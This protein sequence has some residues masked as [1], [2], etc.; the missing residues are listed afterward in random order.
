MVSSVIAGMESERNAAASAAELFGHEVL[1]SETIGASPETPQRACLDLVRRSD[2]VVLILGDR[3][4]SVPPGREM[5]PTHEEYREAR[6]LGKEVL[7]YMRARD[8]EP[9]QRAF[10]DEVR[11]W[12]SGAVMTAFNTPDELR[13]LVIRGLRGIE[14]ARA[15]GG[16]DPK[17]MLARA[18]EAL[19][20][21][22]LR[23]NEPSLALAVAF[24]PAQQALR[25]RQLGEGEFQRQLERDALYGDPAVLVR[26]AGIET[27]IAKGRL[28]LK[29]ERAMLTLATD[30]TIAL[31]VP[32]AVERDDLPMLIEEDV[33]EL[34]RRSLQFAGQLIER[35]DPTGR[36]TD[37]VPV[38]SIGSV[39]FSPWMTR[40]ERARARH[41]YTMNVHAPD[42][43][44]A[45]LQ[46][47]HRRRRALT[48]EA[49]SI[50]EDLT[51]LIRQRI[52]E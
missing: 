44:D 36:L 51:D 52:V 16:T 5:A 45:A 33:V 25:P 47:P 21:V 15:A 12:T 19:D 3:Y 14:L 40:A 10:I 26:G 50:A 7:V 27:A 8:P 22:S 20:G 4:G 37:A 13:D 42:R 41:G 49:L 9:R 18:R 46:P 2:S 24:G 39:G 28:V 1:R 38:A 31:A 32:A 48:A 17:E 23:G 34:V 11:S 43:V 6:D 35:I 29:Q 30:A